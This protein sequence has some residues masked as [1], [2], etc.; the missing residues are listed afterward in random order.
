MPPVSP[1]LLEGIRIAGQHLAGERMPISLARLYSQYTRLRARQPGL[2]SWRA[3]E[4]AERINEAVKLVDGAMLLRQVQDRQWVRDLRR[5]AEILEWVGEG[6]EQPSGIPVMSLA[7]AA[8]GPIIRVLRARK[9]PW[10]MLCIAV[11][12]V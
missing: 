9:P 10:R 8:I 1:E 11:R 2:A 5:A 6:D 7:A 3:N 12:S 4:A